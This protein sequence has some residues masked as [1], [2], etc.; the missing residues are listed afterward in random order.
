MLKTFRLASETNFAQIA[1]IGAA[2]QPPRTSRKLAIHRLFNVIENSLHP[3][4]IPDRQLL[5]HGANLD[6]GV[7]HSNSVL[8]LEVGVLVVIDHHHIHFA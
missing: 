5:A 2:S 8:L 6:E 4:A 1:G 7:L 3:T